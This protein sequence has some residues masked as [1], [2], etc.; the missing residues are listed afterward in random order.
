MIQDKQTYYEYAERYAFG[1]RLR[2]WNSLDQ[3]IR[4]GY[5]GELGIRS[6]RKSDQV[7]LHL[8]REAAIA[9]YQNQIRLN[10]AGFLFFESAPDHLVTLQGEVDSSLD[11]MHYAIGSKTDM[12]NGLREYGQH[13][14]YF[15]T[16]MLLKLYLY[17]SSYSDLVELSLQYPDHVI[18]FSAYSIALGHFR[19][20]NTLIWECR[21]Y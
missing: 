8:S 11:C 6:N 7:Y 4:S 16:R 3:L 10:L 9:I 2:V 15:E 14:T 21:A 5:R 20:R 1:N 12:R 17:P 19:D 18:E 13:S